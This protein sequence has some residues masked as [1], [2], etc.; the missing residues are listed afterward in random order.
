[1]VIRDNENQ[2]ATLRL[3]RPEKLN[4]FNREMAVALQQHL[5]DCDADESIRCVVLTGNGRAFSAGQDLAEFPNGVV[6]AFEQVIDEYYNPLVRLLKSI[7]KPVLCAVN[8]IAA[9]AGANIA[10]ACDIV[11]A[12]ASASF[13]QAFSKI[14]L[15]PDSGGTYF[16][17]RFIGLQKAAAFMMLGDKISA[18][19]AERLGMIYRSVEDAL[20]EE[21]IRSTATTL[22]KLPTTALL[23]TR[24]ALMASYAHSLD[25]QLELEKKLQGQA[26]NTNDF[27]E[28]VTAFL[29]KR[30]PVFRGR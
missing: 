21:T 3:N 13:V 28:G 29:E 14:G 11:I 17:P 5:K 27:K 20:F 2:I 24:Q 9:G 16:L 10:L 6:P 19:E 22:S 23:L 26:G 1:M 18:A 12:A 4:A 30:V 15:I 7:R 25:Q 8:G